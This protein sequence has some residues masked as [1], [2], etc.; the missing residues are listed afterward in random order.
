[1]AW[2]LIIT[3]IT[4][5]TIQLW[6]SLCTLKRENRY[7]L[8]WGSHPRPEP[9][10]TQRVRPWV[11]SPSKHHCFTSVRPQLCHVFVC[12]IIFWNCLSMLK[13]FVLTTLRDRPLV[14]HP[15]SQSNR[16]PPWPDLYTQR[17]AAAWGMIDTQCHL[18][19]MSPGIVNPADICKKARIR[20]YLGVII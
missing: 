7:I 9:I 1:M 2:R 13:T 20:T 15:V 11:S 19:S 12:D 6:Y 5:T 17:A 8:K 4:K 16:T 14:V 3:A 10:F 18:V